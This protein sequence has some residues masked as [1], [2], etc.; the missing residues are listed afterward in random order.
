MKLRILIG[1][2]FLITLSIDA[3]SIDA[4]SIVCELKLRILIGI[5]F[6]ITLSIDAL[7]I[8]CEFLFTMWYLNSTLERD[9][10]FFYLLDAQLY[11]LSCTCSSTCS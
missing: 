1:I 6:L 9:C 10:A 5:V 2:V 3:L 4:L 7:S 11:D 8:V